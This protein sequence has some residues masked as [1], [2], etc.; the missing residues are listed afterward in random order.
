MSIDAQARSLVLL[1]MVLVAFWIAVGVCLS[2]G[3]CGPNN[4]FG[5]S[6]TAY[7]AFFTQRIAGSS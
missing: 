3:A 6:A 1:L 2:L 7:A 5:N 4:S